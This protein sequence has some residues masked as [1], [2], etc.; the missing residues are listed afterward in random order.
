MK[1]LLII[2]STLACIAV[3]LGAFGAHALKAILT[4]AQLDSYQ[5]GVQ[6]QI[7]HAV[8]LIIIGIIYQLTKIRNFITAAYIMLAGI[9]MFSFSIYLLSL[10]EIINLPQLS[11]LGPVTP[12]G[13]SLIIIAWVLVLI[14]ALKL[15]N[16]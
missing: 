8:V 12:I 5:T 11:I 2:G 6:Y 16:D 10:R 1:K 15:K 4:E 7:I 3:I 13:G 9:L 14:N